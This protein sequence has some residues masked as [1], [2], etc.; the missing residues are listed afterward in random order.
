M[1]MMIGNVLSKGKYGGAWAA[2]G[3]VCVLLAG[4]MLV[5]SAFMP[6]DSAEAESGESKPAAAPS[7]TVVASGDASATTAKPNGVTTAGIGEFKNGVQDASDLTF[8]ASVLEALKDGKPIPSEYLAMLPDGGKQIAVQQAASGQSQGISK[9]LTTQ[10]VA[11]ARDQG[12]ASPRATSSNYVPQKPAT[13]GSAAQTPSS[14]SAGGASAPAQQTPPVQQTPAPTPQTPVEQTPPVQQTPPPVQQ[15]PAR[16]TLVDGGLLKSVLGASKSQ[17]ETYFHYNQSL[18]QNGNT[19][20]YLRGSMAVDVTFSGDTATRVSLRFDRFNP[21]G[22]DRNYYETYMMGM[23][24]MS[25]AAPS[26]QSGNS[27]SWSNIYSGASNISFT[28]DLASNSGRVE[29]TR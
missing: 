26:S 28:I 12:T 16:G 18:G 15:P 4:A 22:Q 1:I 25:E 29:A 23:A 11:I 9:P 27:S 8:L 6:T 5:L 24:G 19:L 14:P 17:V 13:G 2:F 3:G 20:S 10:L 21:A 7:N